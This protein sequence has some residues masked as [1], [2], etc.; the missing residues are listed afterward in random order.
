M[1]ASGA[2]PQRTI[3]YQ[4]IAD[5]LRGVVGEVGPGGLLASESALSKRFNASRVTVRKALDLLRDEGLIDSRQ[6]FG[7]F[8]ATEPVPQRLNS[9]TTIE[10]Q[11]GE[12]GMRAARRVLEFAFVDSTPRVAEVLGCEQVL[13]VKRLNL[14]NGSPFAVVTVWCP[15]D[16]GHQLSRREVEAKPFYEL[17]NVQLRGATQ[18]IV[19]DAATVDEAALLS[20]PVGSPVLRCERVTTDTHGHPVLLSE[21]VFAG[22]RT[23]LVVDL[24]NAEPSIAPAGLR[25]VD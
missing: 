25:L 21:H 14:A 10:S 9:L 13:R 4:Q 23:Q 22:L 24:P 16:H 1:Q 15:A 7:W 18:T 8:A 11:L 20:V 3:R 2:R 5:E 19:A 6:G 12:R 17:L